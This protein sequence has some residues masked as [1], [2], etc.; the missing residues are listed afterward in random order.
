MMRVYDKRVRPRKFHD[1]DIVLKKNIPIQ[2]TSEENGCRIG[3]DLITL[4]LTEM[5]GRNLRNPMNS[6]SVKR[7]FT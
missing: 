7:Y 3:K 2:K 4:I 5:D 6:N 1:E